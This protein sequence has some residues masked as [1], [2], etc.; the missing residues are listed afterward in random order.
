MLKELTLFGEVD[1][2]QKAIDRLRMFEPPDGYIL[3]F[4]GGKDSQCIL[5]LAKEAGVKFEAH[6]HLTTVD[7]P[8]LIYF[9]RDHYPEVIFD[10]PEITMWNLIVK[11]KMP[12]TRLV[13]YCC[14]HLKEGSGMGRTVIT[15]IRWAESNRR[16]QK[17]SMLEINA[18]SKEKI[19]LNSDN[20]EA[21][22]MFETCTMRDSGVSDV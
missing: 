3:A 2:V 17:R 19:M 7:P 9:I 20:D 5:H 15:G 1:K 21:R 13:R 10:K 4:S 22:R 11:K 16:K 6:Y 8:E 12:P 14:E 18:Y